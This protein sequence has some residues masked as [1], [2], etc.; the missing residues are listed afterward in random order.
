MRHPAIIHKTVAL[1][2]IAVLL[3][4]PVLSVTGGGVVSPFKPPAT[5]L[6]FA[7]NHNGG[8]ELPFQK[9]EPEHPVSVELVENRVLLSIGE[10]RQASILPPAVVFS[11]QDF[12]TE[13]YTPPEIA[14]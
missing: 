5:T 8:E 3:S 4:L 6:Y 2:V 11:P 7:T 9:A 14:S 13:I 12:S 1:A 10:W